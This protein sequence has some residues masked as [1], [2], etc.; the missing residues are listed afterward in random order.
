MLKSPADFFVSDAFSVACVLSKTPRICAFFVVAW[1][2]VITRTSAILSIT[3]DTKIE[4]LS[5]INI[6][7]RKACLVMIS[8]IKY[9]VVTAVGLDTG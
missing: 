8:V 6:V 4:P 2:S 1:R 5:I 7:G 9:A 3:F